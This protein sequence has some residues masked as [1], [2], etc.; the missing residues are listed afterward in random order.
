MSKCEDVNGLVYT[1]R[2]ILTQVEFEGVS[3]LKK[4]WPELFC[5]N[6]IQNPQKS[7]KILIEND[8]EKLKR[9]I[10][11][12]FYI[13]YGIV[14]II[15]LNIEKNQIFWLEDEYSHTLAQY[16][17]AKPR[18]LKFYLDK[19]CTLIEACI[20]LVAK[21]NLGFFINPLNVVV[22]KNNRFAIRDIMDEEF[23]VE[24]EAPEFVLMN[25]RTSDCVVWSIGCLLVYIAKLVGDDRGKDEMVKEPGDDLQ[26]SWNM[27]MND[28]RGKSEAE[29]K[30]EQEYVFGLFDKSYK[31]YIN[32]K[33][34]GLIKDLLKKIFKLKRNKRITLSQLY[35]E[36]QKIIE[37]G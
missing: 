12:T 32:H 8:E 2:H 15:G 30:I 36:L 5:L 1:M 10:T 37:L 3:I 28:G 18:P 31:N 20:Y 22:I 6:I 11:R 17:K 27:R 35:I 33:K 29:K 23:L 14:Q 13:H 34:C 26:V 9:Q 4:S 19:T 21:G 16:L 24:F 25:E 7:R